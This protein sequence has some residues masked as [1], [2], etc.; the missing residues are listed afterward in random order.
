MDFVVIFAELKIEHFTSDTWLARK[1]A[2]DIGVETTI[3]CGMVE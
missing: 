3:L 2:G 1:R